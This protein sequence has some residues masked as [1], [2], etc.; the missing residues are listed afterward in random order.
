MEK[1]LLEINRYK[2]LMNIVL[3]TESGKV[4]DEFIPI[5]ARSVDNLRKQGVDFAN[6][7]SKLSD[8]FT[9][10][11]IKT[12]DD[13]TAVVASKNPTIDPKNITD[14]MIKAYIKNDDKLYKSILAKAASAAAAEA[15]TLVKNADVTAIFKADP[16]QLVNAQRL[17]GASPNV[18]TIDTLI[19][20]VDDSIVS[21][22]KTIDE[23][24]MGNVPGVTTV[25]KDLDELYEQLLAKSS[26]LKNYK[27]KDVAPEPVKFPDPLPPISDEAAQKVIQNSESKI[28]E[29]FDVL[30]GNAKMKKLYAPGLS[31]EQ[32]ELTR[33]FIKAKYGNIPLDQL[34][35]NLDQVQEDMVKDLQRKVNS[36]P[37]G[38]KGTPENPELKRKA[39]AVLD[40]L[41]DNKITRACFGSNKAVV[42]PTLKLSPATPFK[43]IL[44]IYSIR[45]AFKMLEWVNS[46]SIEQDPLFCPFLTAGGFCKTMTG[47]GWCV[48]SCSEGE[49]TEWFPNVYEN[50]F[51]PDF[52]KWVTDKGFT[53]PDLNIDDDGVETFL[54]NDKENN[55]Q[56]ATYDG[57]KK[58]FN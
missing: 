47:K 15:D 45:V 28:D 31:D 36:I 16:A 12:F 7:L 53:N 39:G 56:E 24:N 9:N 21:I 6:D 11:G 26:D 23:I 22:E 54:Y 20:G 44:C 30:V 10:Q 35:K 58:T 18:R 25:P 4:V 32:I 49:D 13:L 43:A 41:T 34:L 38:A 55:R 3:L 37:T 19:Q 29:V 48:K 52:K 8:E 42:N 27:N 1:L 2:Q 51:D 40:F 50:K 33:Q 5:S 14:D 17:L 46:P 57:G